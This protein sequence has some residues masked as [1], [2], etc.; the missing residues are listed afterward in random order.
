LAAPAGMLNRR[1]LSSASRAA[2]AGQCRASCPNAMR[3]ASLAGNVVGWYVRV[4]TTQIADGGPLTVLYVVGHPTPAEAEHAVKQVRSLP[5]EKYEVLSEA[6]PGRG[7]QPKP[8]QV[9]ELKGAL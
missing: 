8:G 4:T 7:P 2:G 9:W 6:V 1:T 3:V 5:G